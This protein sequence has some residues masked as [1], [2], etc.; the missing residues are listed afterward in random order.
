MKKNTIMLRNI[1]LL[2]VIIVILQQFLG[3]LILIAERSKASICGRSLL[4]LVR[5]PS[6]ARMSV[7]YECCVFV[8]KS[9]LRRADHSSRGVLPCCFT[10]CD[11]ETLRLRRP[12]P[13]LGCCSRK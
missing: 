5:I 11:I 10:V 2:R 9:S 13:A 7:S 3:L 12:W 4:G 1:M 8:R 6:V